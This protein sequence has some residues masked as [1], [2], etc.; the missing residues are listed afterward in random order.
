MALGQLRGPSLETNTPLHCPN[1]ENSVA[2]A[3]LGVCDGGHRL[4]VMKEETSRLSPGFL[5]RRIGID[6]FEIRRIPF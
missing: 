1:L 3:G 2:L 6:T 5:T 4:D